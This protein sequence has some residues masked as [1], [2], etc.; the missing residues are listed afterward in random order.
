MRLNLANDLKL[1]S[2]EQKFL[3]LTI[4]EIRND[5][6]HDISNIEFNLSD[7]LQSLRSSRKTEIHKRFKPFILDEKVISFEDFCN[8]CLNLFFTSCCIEIA[9]IH[10]ETEGTAA[11]IKHA[12]YRARQALKLLPRIAD[13]ALFIEDKWMVDDYIKEAKEGLM[14]AGILKTQFVSKN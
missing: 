3:F 7:Y 10:G 9:K 6:I 14:K 5:Y 4:A 12:E 8:D 2:K 13:N 11:Q 1:I